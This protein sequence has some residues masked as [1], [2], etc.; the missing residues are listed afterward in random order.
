VASLPEIV[1]DRLT[2]ARGVLELLLTT[3]LSLEQKHYALALG[4]LLA[5]AAEPQTVLP[6]A[7][8]DAYIDPDVL[9]ELHRYLP[10]SSCAAILAQ[11]RSTA[12]ELLD[13]ALAALATEQSDA[14]A[15]AAHSLIGTAGAVGMEILAQ[16]ARAIVVA[17]R[18]GDWDGAAARAAQLPDIYDASSIALDATVA[19]LNNSLT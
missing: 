10:P 13:A 19:E 9:A 5:D 2:A 18:H 4:S 16:E 6:T 11:F 7:S 14:L 1:P 3:D 15:R 12:R 17:L 8:D